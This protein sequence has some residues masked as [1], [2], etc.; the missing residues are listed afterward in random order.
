MKNVEF[1]SYQFYKKTPPN[2]NL[3]HEEVKRKSQK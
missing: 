1:I 2:L 3:K